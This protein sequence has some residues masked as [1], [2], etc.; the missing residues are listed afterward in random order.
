MTLPRTATFFWAMARDC[1]ADH[2]FAVMD[3]RPEY[4]RLHV[5]VPCK[6]RVRVRIPR[7]NEDHLSLSVRE[8]TERAFDD[9]QVGRCPTR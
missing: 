7:R 1:R 6:P 3:M 5:Y 2:D 8:L 9:G 4:V